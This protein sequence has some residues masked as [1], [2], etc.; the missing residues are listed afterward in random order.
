MTITLELTPKQEA[1]LKRKAALK[2]VD[3]AAYLL[4]MASVEIESDNADTAAFPTE[5]DRENEENPRRYDPVNPMT[6]REAFERLDKSG[7]LWRTGILEDTV[8]YA[9][10]LR[11]RVQRR[12][13]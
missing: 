10:S 3:V 5:P 7:A 1:V 4:A 12:T 11:E 13:R 8:E 9:Q 6:G 2:G